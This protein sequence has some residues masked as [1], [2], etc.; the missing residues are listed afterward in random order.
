MGLGLQYKEKILPQIKFKYLVENDKKPRNKGIVCCIC[1]KK[2]IIIGS[3]A[4]AYS[5]KPKFICEDCTIDNYQYDYGFKSRKVATAY[6]RRMFDVGYLFNEMVT[7]KYL[8]EKNINSMDELDINEIN[9]IL[10]ISRDVYNNL[11]SRRK[12]IKLKLTEKQEDIEKK[13]RKKL[14]YVKFEK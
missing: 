7:D 6:R 3:V 1:G 12:K 13:L 9:Y 2:N 8:A 11:F 5:N 10:D 4:D 14:K